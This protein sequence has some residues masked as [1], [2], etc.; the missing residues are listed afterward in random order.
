MLEGMDQFILRP[1]LV[2]YAKTGE[3]ELVNSSIDCSFV[4][5]SVQSAFNLPLKSVLV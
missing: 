4:D 3:M 1:H 2:L 5:K